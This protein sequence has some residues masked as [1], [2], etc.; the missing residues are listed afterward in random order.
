MKIEDIQNLP[1]TQ[2]VVESTY[3]PGYLES[4]NNS[5]MGFWSHYVLKEDSTEEL[6]KALK[7]RDIFSIEWNLRLGANPNV[8]DDEGN[9]IL[10]IAALTGEIALAKLGCLHGVDL[11]IK[12]VKKKTALQ[13]SIF[14]NSIL[15]NKKN[16]LT[17]VLLKKVDDIL[18]YDLGNF[19]KPTSHFFFEAFN[20]GS[21]AVIENIGNKYLS[22]KTFQNLPATKKQFLLNEILKHTILNASKSEN[23]EFLLLAET[24]LKARANPNFM[25]NKEQE[26][27]LLHFTKMHE[28]KKLSHVLVQYGASLEAKDFKGLKPGE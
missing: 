18:D 2:Q 14:N 23:S 5:I 26:R 13:E 21:K 19:I 10:H 7:E 27:T 8:I 9:T 3:Q 25:F 20:Q 11:K 6:T 1:E 28:L 24:Y 12:N 16:L 4:F 22:S 15:Y 17:Q